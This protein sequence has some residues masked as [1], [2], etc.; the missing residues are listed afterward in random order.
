MNE[1]NGDDGLNVTL[2]VGMDGAVD[3]E[4]REEIDGRI[5]R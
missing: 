2:D 1:S 5:D 4:A 3:K